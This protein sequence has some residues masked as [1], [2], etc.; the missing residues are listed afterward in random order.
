MGG[1]KVMI[2]PKKLDKTQNF[3]E[4]MR[5]LSDKRNGQQKIKAEVAI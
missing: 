1:I 2:H 3:C 5:H 4:R